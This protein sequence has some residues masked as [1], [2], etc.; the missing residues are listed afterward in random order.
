MAAACFFGRGREPEGEV[1]EHLDEHAAEAERD[2]LA[3]RGVRHGADDDLGGG[4]PVGQLTL[5]QD[6]VYGGV[7]MPGTSVLDDGLAGLPE[8][9]VAVEPD[10]DP[11]DVGLVQYVA[12]FDLG[13]DGIADLRGDRAG[14]VPRLRDALR[15]A[16]ECRKRRRPAWPRP[17]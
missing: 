11:A 16:S 9:R 1:L 15:P 6:A 14:F 13:D 2:Q 8:R 7:G 5:D 4:R 17:R 12:R 10:D 3:E